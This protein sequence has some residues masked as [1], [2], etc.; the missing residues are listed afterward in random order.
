MTNEQ[1]TKA[2]IVKIMEK[3]TAVKTLNEI[4]DLIGGVDL[5]EICDDVS[6]IK[7]EDIQDPIQKIL[8]AAIQCGLVYWSEE[9]N[10]LVQKLIR[11]VKSGEITADE[12]KYKHRLSINELKSINAKNELDLFEKGLSQMVA[13]PS[14]LIGRLTG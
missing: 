5:M 9:E 11:P 13:R 2:Q 3:E 8:I 10:C 4:K 12:F 14:Q 7:L 6:E 1:Q